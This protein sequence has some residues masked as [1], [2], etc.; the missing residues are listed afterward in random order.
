MATVNLGKIKPL[1]RGEYNSSATYRPLD[2][3]SFNNET[4]INILES[5]G[6]V[7][8]NATYFEKVVQPDNIVHAPGSGL[9]NE[10]SANIVPF[11]NAG[12]SLSS[13]D[14]QN[15]IVET[16]NRI[17]D[18]ELHA[19]VAWTI[20]DN[21]TGA[22][23]TRGSG[24]VQAHTNM[25]RCVLNDNGTVNYYLDSNNSELKDDGVTASVLD[26]TD[27]QVM[28][29]IPRTWFR[30][31]QRGNKTLYAVTH[32]ERAGFQLHPVFC[33]NAGNPIYSHVYAAAY[34]ASVFD[35]SAGTYIDGLNLDNNTGRVST[36]NDKLASV[37]GRFPMVGL[38]RN[39]FR[40][41]A[42]NRGTGWQLTDFW[43]RDLIKL[44]FVTEYGNWNS[45]AVVGDGN[46]NR[47][48]VGSSSNQSDSPHVVAGVSN[49]LGNQTGAAVSP[50]PYVSYRGLENLWGNC[51]NWQDGINLLDRQAYINNEAATFADNTANG[52]L[53]LGVSLPVAS[54]SFIKGLQPLEKGL[55]P[56]TVG[57]SSSTFIAD[58]M[59]TA[60]GWRVVLVGGHADLGG[61]AGVSAFGGNFGSSERRRNFGSRL[62]YKKLV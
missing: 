23:D 54:A 30:L 13:V 7:P 37:S 50:D 33:D 25:R 15:A 59:W 46:V 4:Y 40:L 60:T 21:V 27:G 1:W 34:D 11:N 2:F 28:V 45:Q 18:F 42:A 20:Y 24:A 62:T 39:D 41:I 52:Y 26:G 19:D 48:Y 17:S 58:A 14:V 3:V 57:G 9:P 22:Y 16:N 44:L 29:E 10:L 49:V 55:L 51:W 56:A 36:A 53:T 35:V 6:I 32:R 38:T 61:R 43:E 47:S 12:T 5:T 8:T 31:E